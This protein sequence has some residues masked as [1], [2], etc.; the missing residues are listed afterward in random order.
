MSK[1]IHAATAI[2]ALTLLAV[3]AAPGAGLA[4]PE[5][6]LKGGTSFPKAFSLP[7]MMT[8]H[9][10]PNLEKMTG[11][12]LSLEAHIAGS[13]CN[14]KSCVEQVKL[15]QTDLATVSIANFGG[16]GKTF[17]ILTLPYI[18]ADSASAKKVMT[19]FLAKELR[20][21]AEKNDGLKVIAVVPMLGFRALQHNA[22][23]PIKTPA[24]IRNVKIR[25]TKSP[26]D[27]ALLRAW[28]ATATPVDWSETYDA[29]RQ[30]VVRGLYIQ[31]GVYVMMKFNEVAPHMT[32]TD[33][34]WSSMMFFMDS[35]RYK[36]LPD[37]AR[38]AIDKASDALQADAFEI[39]GKFEAKAQESVAKA[40]AAGKA[41]VYKPNAKEMA[42]WRKSSAKAW[43]VGKK[44][45]LYDPKLALRIL[46]AQ[47]GQE[48]FI[49]ELKKVGAL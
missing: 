22:D 28:G 20:Q 37:W 10:K 24:D 15:G 42:A 44:L 3:V 12:R 13:L 27:G 41:K 48:E 33:G 29:V 1:S 26:L 34:A 36:K 43:L 32:L 31:Q 18:F 45:N 5:I 19:S 16:F 49:A 30:K 39:D 46:Q 17:E 23:K 8:D 47:E 38:A 9:L 11:G 6:V 35:N 2:A 21:T 4:A 14:E 7:A 40:Q 25:V